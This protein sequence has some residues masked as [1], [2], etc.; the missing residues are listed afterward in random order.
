[1]ALT[2]NRELN[3]YVDQELRSFPLAAAEH[4][5]KGAL[6]GVERSTGCVRNL[7]A[8][9]L[10]AGVAYEEADNSAGVAGALSVRAYT[11]GDFILPAQ[12][13]SEDLL[14]SPVYALSDEA[15]TANPAAVGASY[16][17]ILVGVAGATEGIVRIA[18]L[19][20]SQIERALQVPLTSL[21]TAATTNP[22]MIAQRTI[23]ILSVQVSFNTVPNQGL[24]DLGTDA[25][26]P[27]EIVD[28][29]NLATLTAHTPRLLTLMSTLVQKG[30]RVWAKVGQ[31][32]TTAG[33]GGMLSIRYVELP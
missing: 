4:I 6:L 31:A 25:T 28:A 15:V 2:A 26:D 13:L 22:V 8:G 10:F 1:M 27:D 29:F 9:D 7:V 5:W 30:Q 19:S 18:P 20:A 17:G 11:Q 24:L 33:V 12:S 23:V 21:T 3:R 32:S 16:C 14:G